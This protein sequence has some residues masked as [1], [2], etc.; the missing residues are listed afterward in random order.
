MYIYYLYRSRNPI[1]PQNL[2]SPTN[3]FETQ[4]RR[5]RHTSYKPYIPKINKGVLKERPF[6]SPLVLN[7]KAPKKSQKRSESS[8][9]SK[10]FILEWTSM[11]QKALPSPSPLFQ[12]SKPNTAAK[13]S[14]SPPNLKLKPRRSNVKPL[15]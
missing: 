13:N 14:T 1:L 5:T 9:F 11:A 4:T 15:N 10:T 12:R 3:S 7:Y 2:R 8:S 6:S